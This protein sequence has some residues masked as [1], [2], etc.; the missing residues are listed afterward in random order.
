MY[1]SVFLVGFVPVVSV[2]HIVFIASLAERVMFWRKTSASMAAHYCC[3]RVCTG[4]IFPSRPCI[5]VSICAYAFCSFSD[6]AGFP[7]LS[8]SPKRSRLL[9]G[10]FH[11][12]RWVG[13]FSKNIRETKLFSVRGN[14]FFHSMR[15]KNIQTS[16]IRQALFR[17]E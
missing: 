13:G 12:T 6:P 11:S 1:W 16:E 17:R 4:G 7:C 2:T 9:N 15:A 10:V 5:P 3:Q 14:A 8:S